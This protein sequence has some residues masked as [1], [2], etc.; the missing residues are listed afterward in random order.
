VP[1]PASGGTHLAFTLPDAGPVSLVVFD[2]QGRRVATVLER[3]WRAAGP[4]GAVV[5]TAELAPGIYF[6]R[7]E[8]RGSARVTRFVVLR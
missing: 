1:N 8:W 3:A 5:R 4:H 6:A 7:L 2:A